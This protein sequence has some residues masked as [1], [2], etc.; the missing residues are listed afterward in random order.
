MV[1]LVKIIELLRFLHSTELYQVY[2]IEGLDQGFNNVCIF[3]K[4][5]HIFKH[6]TYM[7]V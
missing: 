7:Y 3:I 5:K 2:F 1:V 4:I 6:H